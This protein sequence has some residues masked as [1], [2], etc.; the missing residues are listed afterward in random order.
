MSGEI[1]GDNRFE[2]IERAKKYIIEN[3]NIETSSKEI[4]VLDN[5]LFRLWQLGLLEKFNP[6]SKEYKWMGVTWYKYCK[7]LLPP[8]SIEVIAYNHKWINEDFNPN[9][10]RVGFRTSDDDFISAYWWDYQDDYV[11]ISGWKCEGNPEFSDELVKNRK[12]EWWT[13]ISNFREARNSC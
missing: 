6:E 8:I 13:Y 3:T 9:G 11:G 5:I 2:I 12:P 10:T 7:D 4:E 1:C